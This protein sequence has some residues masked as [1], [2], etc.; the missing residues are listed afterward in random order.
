M[1]CLLFHVVL[2]PS[3]THT[4]SQPCIYRWDFSLSALCGWRGCWRRGQGKVKLQDRS[5]DGSSWPS[6]HKLFPFSFLLVKSIVLKDMHIIPKRGLPVNKGHHTYQRCWLIKYLLRLS[7][8]QNRCFWTWA[9]DWAYPCVKIV[10]P[11]DYLTW[12]TVYKLC[13]HF[14]ISIKSSN[15]RGT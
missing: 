14:N 12:P 9:P 11:W 13:T 2:Q 4:P 7:I 5:E 8:S 6:A 1:L 15:P 3:S 10:L